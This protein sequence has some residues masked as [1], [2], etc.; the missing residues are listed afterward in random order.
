MEQTILGH[1]SIFLGPTILGHAS[2]FLGPTI[3]GNASIFLRPT[4]VGHSSIFLVGGCWSWGRIDC[5]SW[6]RIDQPATKSLSTS[7]TVDHNTQAAATPCDQGNA[8]SA[9]NAT[10]NSYT[11]RVTSVTDSC[12]HASQQKKKNRTIKCYAQ[13]ATSVA[14]RISHVSLR[15][16]MGLGILHAL[17]RA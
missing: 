11:T 5:W 1:A 6:G 7:A 2:I 9:I 12:K 13:F 16:G 3:V 15:A 14:R 17:F 10:S 8:T 4:I